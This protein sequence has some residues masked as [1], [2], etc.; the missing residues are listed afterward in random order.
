MFKDLGE[1]RALAAEI[2]Q[3]AP[4]VDSRQVAL[5]PPAIALATVV[6]AVQGAQREIV[7][8]AQNM[9][10]EP[11]GAYTGEISA[12]MIRAAGGQAV[13][14]GHSERRHKLGESD[15]FVGKKVPKALEGGLVPLLCVGEKIEERKAGE[16]TKVVAR[17]LTAGLS[18]VKDAAQLKKVVVA[19]EPVWAIGTGM[20]ATPQQGQEVHGFIRGHLAAT[21][22]SLGQST[23]TA[24]DLAEECLILYGGSVNAENAADILAERDIDGV[25]VG[26]ASLK[27]DSFLKICAAG[28]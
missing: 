12:R 9:H 1:A 16:T 7:V 2:A 20:T 15:E 25:L 10:F 21:F 17:Q 5:F 13:I 23:E 19:Y 24:A 27:A 8:G 18:G 26:G 11:E 22:R 4:A 6:E 14:L 3:G 28:L